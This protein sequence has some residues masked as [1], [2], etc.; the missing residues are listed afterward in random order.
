MK[1]VFKIVVFFGLAFFVFSSSWNNADNS[2]V[3]NC[4]TLDTSKIEK[5]ENISIDNVSSFFYAVQLENLTIN[6]TFGQTSN[7]RIFCEDYLT[8]PEVV[9]QIFFSTYTQYTSNSINFINR[10]KKSDIIFP[11]HYFW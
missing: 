8:F 1:K 2:I 10:F 7:F 3:K 5:N 6:S 9:E 4:K 11:F